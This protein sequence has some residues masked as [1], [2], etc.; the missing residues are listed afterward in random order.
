MTDP[1]SFFTKRNCIPLVFPK[2]PLFS[3]FALFF[4]KLIEKAERTK[5]CTRTRE[6]PKGKNYDFIYTNSLSIKSQEL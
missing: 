3:P 2:M 6:I 1:L 5:R 4:I